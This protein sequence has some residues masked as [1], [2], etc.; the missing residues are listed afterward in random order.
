[1]YVNLGQHDLIKHTLVKVSIL[2]LLD[3]LIQIFGPTGKQQ[4]IL[5]YLT[6]L[7][8]SYNYHTYEHSTF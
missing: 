7:N 4:V 5:T 8:N 3:I 6:K 2:D 1:M